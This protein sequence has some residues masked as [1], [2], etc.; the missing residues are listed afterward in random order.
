MD[1]SSASSRER[2]SH[3]RERVVKHHLPRLAAEFYCGQSFIHWTLTINNRATGWLTPE[4]HQASQLILLHTCSRYA[5][6]CPVYVLMPDH[7]HLLSLGLDQNG[8]D[9]RV[10]LEF[11]RKHLRSALSP[12]SW[13]H[14]AHD[15][16]LREDERK[17]GAVQTVA[18]YILENPVQAKLA[19]SVG[20]YPFLG[21]CVPGYPGLQVALPDYWE[22]FW[23]IYQRL[24]GESTRSR[25]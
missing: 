3:E 14:Q 17:H 8:T 19:A 2:S 15:H 23:R 6:V 7:V 13:Q 25:S 5:L 21:C 12:A 4:F 18:H 22:K 9:Q 20:N 10:A 1:S 11:L 24:I 16:V